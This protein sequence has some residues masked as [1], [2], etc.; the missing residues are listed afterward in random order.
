[1]K[2]HVW[3]HGAD[4]SEPDTHSRSQLFL[5][6]S[7]SQSVSASSEPTS[8][9]QGTDEHNSCKVST[10]LNITANG[11]PSLTFRS[12]RRFTASS[13]C[14]SQAIWKPPIPLM[15]IIFPASSSEQVSDNISGNDFTDLSPM[16]SSYSGPQTEQATGC[17]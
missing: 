15:A 12:R 9:L 17:A 2:R 13:F 3:Q 4:G 5:F 16:I 8:S 7:Q 1:M 14:A 11:F 6:L 10:F